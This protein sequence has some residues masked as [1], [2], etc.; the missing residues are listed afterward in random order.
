[1]TSEQQT[2]YDLSGFPK[3]LW[4][5]NGARATL[6]PMVSADEPEL[7]AFFLR[8]PEED[9]RYLKDDVTSP[10]VIRRWAREIDYSNVLPILAEVEGRI[11]AD[12]SL[13][14]SPQPYRPHS[15]EVR[16]VVDPSFRTMGLGVEMAR[17][18]I[19]LAKQANLQDVYF[20]LAEEGEAAAVRAAKRLGFTDAALY[21]R[22]R[23]DQI[24]EPF[25]LLIMELHLHEQEIHVRGS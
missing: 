20:E 14:R 18:L 2:G 9:R 5:R 7:L 11:V 19:S 21:M 22:R 23:R 12:A 1:M 6:R 13:H 10:E 16:V 15:A 4:L 24:G 8:V 3:V 25:D 17:E